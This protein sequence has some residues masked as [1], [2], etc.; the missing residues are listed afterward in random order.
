MKGT[1]INFGATTIKDI[2]KEL[3]LSACTISRALKDSYQI[4]AKTKEIVVACAQKYNYQP[5]SIAQTLK[6]GQSKTIG[7][8]VSTIE[9]SFFSQIVNGIESVAND[10][11]YNVF[12]TQSHESYELEVCNVQHLTS[13]SIDGLLVSL[14]TETQD[15]SHF[16][17]A[18]DKGLP[19]VFFDRVPDEIDT[20]KVVADNFMGAYDATMHLISA[21]YQKIAHITS[22]EH[23]PL[24]VQ[25][26]NGYKTALKDSGIVID[27]KQIKYCNH[28]GKDNLEIENALAELLQDENRPDAIFTASDRITTTTFSLLRNRNIK[29]PNEIALM[30]FTNTDLAEIFKPS[31]SSVYQPGFEM[32]RK[33][34]EILIELIE[35]KRPVLEFETVML[36]T[37]LFIRNSSRPQLPK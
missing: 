20:H 36:P 4:G 14:S 32:G 35:K 37:K 13:K 15:V 2:A 22:S 19:I 6:M 5:N 8:V 9:N 30:G 18:N 16:K 17:N 25:R 23:I 27:E 33:A 21:G 24:T 7:I 34:A 12:I 26:L 29:I 1:K 3:N 28:G 10:K 11:G 31:L